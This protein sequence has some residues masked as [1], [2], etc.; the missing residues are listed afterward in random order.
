MKLALPF[1]IVALG[2]SACAQKPVTVLQPVTRYV[3]PPRVSCPP[4]PVLRDP[5]LP[6]FSEEDV[7]NYVRD[8]REAWYKCYYSAQVQNRF[9]DEKRKEAE[10]TAASEAAAT[11]GN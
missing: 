3:F 10:A 1:L 7:K 2:L 8:L 4:E 6:G 11:E 5:T 9:L